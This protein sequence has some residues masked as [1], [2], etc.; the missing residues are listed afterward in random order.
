M[1]DNSDKDKERYWSGPGI[2]VNQV[3]VV[4]L[5]SIHMTRIM[6]SLWT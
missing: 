3:M 4:S 2:K 6:S 5:D 1:R